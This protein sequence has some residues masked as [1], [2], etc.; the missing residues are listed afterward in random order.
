MR[1]VLTIATLVLA[2]FA[3]PAV[4]GARATHEIDSWTNE[5]SEWF[6]G[7]FCTG[8]AVGGTGYE[9]GSARITETA[10]GGSHVTGSATGSVPLFKANGP[11]PWDPQF[12]DYVG[13]WTYTVKFDEE[14]GPDGQSTEGSVAHG[15]VVYADGSSQFRQVLFHLV[16]PQD[17][18][19]KLFLV[20]LVCGG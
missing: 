15:R 9:S 1:R 11:G 6:Q 8:Y 2:A 14:V 3:L 12:G 17:G 16:L 19:P 20:R 18:P 13:T 7:D 5:P 4:A 10:N